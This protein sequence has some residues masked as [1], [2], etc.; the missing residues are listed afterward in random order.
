MLMILVTPL[1]D[2]MMKLQQLP[3]RNPLSEP[4][5][6]ARAALALVQGFK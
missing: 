4:H 6:A 2:V 1:E 5:K 3:G